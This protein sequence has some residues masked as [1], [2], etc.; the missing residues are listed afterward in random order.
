MKAETKQSRG[1]R[2]AALL[3]VGSITAGLLAGCSDKAETT[4]TGSPSTDPTATTTAEARPDSWISDTPIEFTALYSDNSSFPFKDDWLVLEEIRK[5]TN[6]TLKFQVIPDNDFKDKR[7]LVLSG[8]DAPDLILKTWPDDIIQYSNPDTLVPINEVMEKLPNFQQRM[9]ETEFQTEYDSYFKMGDGNYYLLPSWGG[10]VISTQVLFYRADLY[11]KHQIPVPTTYGELADGLKQL[12]TLY[13]NSAPLTNRFGEGLLLGPIG[14][15]FGT[16]AGWSLPNGYTYDWDNNKWVFAPTTD[17]YKQMTAYLRELVASDVLDKEAFT[18]DGNVFDQKLTTGVS[19]AGYG[20]LGEEIKYNNEGKK[21]VGPEYDLKWLDPLAGPGGKALT[22]SEK[23]ASSGVAI[24]AKL[25]KS[26]NFDKLLKF[27]D[28][29][30]YSDEG[31]T[32][33]TWGVEGV[34][35]QVVDGKKQLMDDI[36]KWDNTDGT[37][38]LKKDYGLNIGMLSGY[39]P[40]DF[41]NALQNPDYIAYYDKNEANKATPLDDPTVQMNE[42]ELEQVKLLVTKL[43]DYTK[44]ML[45]KF[46]LGTSDLDKDWDSYVKECE[47]KGSTELVNIVNQAWARTNP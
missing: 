28:W 47:K 18:Q 12:K 36:I 15:S 19:F 35:Y 9:Q 8:G 20:W 41:S 5:R 14:R 22:K 30:W 11:A 21:N 10:R 23:R 29:L 26:E 6:V 46:V 38:D 42:N 40:K 13:P 31:T 3:L 7:S 25:Q 27:V 39:A 43:N 2:L 33:T 45:Y 44:Q 32:L 34:T 4:A 24:N 16:N 17:G 37:K 1:K